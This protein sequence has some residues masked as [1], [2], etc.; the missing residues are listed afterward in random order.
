LP[1]SKPLS[2]RETQKHPRAVR[3]SLISQ[4]WTTTLLSQVRMILMLLIL[5]MPVNYIKRST[6]TKRQVVSILDSGWATSDTDK[7]RS[8]SQTVQATKEPG[9]SAELRV[10]ET[11]PTPTVMSTVGLGCRIEH[12]V[13]E[14][15]RTTV[16]VSTKVA[17]LETDKMA[18]AEKS[19]L[20]VLASKVIFLRERKKALVFI[21]GQT[22]HL[23]KV[24]GWTIRL[25]DLEHMHGLKE[26]S[27]LDSGK[28]A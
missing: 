19:Y 27:T 25:T 6:T 24:S 12:K 18:S 8:N 14:H 20:T 16:E 22:E 17:G 26:E 7:E 13:T 11:S 2:K 21:G 23:M 4:T 10:K 5:T 28:I 3:T 15:I 9:T 1:G